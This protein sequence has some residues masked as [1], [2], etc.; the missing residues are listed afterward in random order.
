[1]KNQ[2]KK[3]TISLWILVGAYDVYFW[4]IFP[5]INELK[6]F[7]KGAALYACCVGILNVTGAKPRRAKWNAPVL[8]F[9]YVLATITS[10]FFSVSSLYVLV[11]SALLAA[12][13][14][15]LYCLAREG[16]LATDESIMYVF[17]WLC[18]CAVGASLAGY[19]VSPGTFATYEGGLRRLHGV[20]GEPARLALAAGLTM[21][22]A[23]VLRGNV[24]FRV[25]SFLAGATCLIMT[26]SRTPLLAT[27]VSIM[28]V[29]AFYPFRFKK[30]FWVATCF[31]VVIAF[32]VI[33]VNG[34]RIGEVRYMRPES[35]V[36]LTGRTEL[37]IKAIPEAV[38]APFGR[39]YCLGG[40]VFLS[41]DEKNRGSILWKKDRFK[42][43]SHTGS[44]KSSLHSGYIQALCD[45]GVGG[46]FVYFACFVVGA[47]WSLAAARKNYL[48][49]HVVCF[50]YIACANFTE[51]VV[52]GPTSSYVVLFWIVWF[53][54]WYWRQNE[55]HKASIVT[56]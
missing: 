13:M 39:G 35:I 18:S 2:K 9:L 14:V 3:R 17:F 1:M 44:Y 37:W 34:I 56:M 29:G 48:L 36:N 27:I 49:P 23:V 11:Q 20:Y 40:S 43:L 31:C 50:W 7:I 19:F 28:I 46:F 5:N 30:L 25:I 24:C 21:L 10:S 42:I 51:S 12:L 38:R 22:L 6:L 54:L 26:G 53:S 55:R 33:V 45:T 15:F 4:T 8:P 32:G 41:D 47:S 52:M 16:V